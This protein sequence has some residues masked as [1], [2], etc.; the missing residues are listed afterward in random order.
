[1]IFLKQH[2]ELDTSSTTLAIFV[3]STLTL[4]CSTFTIIIYL[5]MKNLRTLVY[6]FFFHVA[7][8]EWINRL[9]YLAILISEIKTNVISFRIFSVIIY[10]SNTNIIILT[11]FTCFGM[12]QLILKQNTKL[13]DKF[14]KISIFLYIGSAVFTVIFDF[15]SR[16]DNN[17]K[18]KETNIYRNIICLYFITDEENKNLASVL[19][20]FILYLLILIFS[21][22][23]IILIQIFV[24][25][26]ASIPRNMD[27]EAETMKDK[28][29][30]SSLKLRTFK[31]KLL[32]YPFLNFS[33][34]VPLSVYLWIEYA[35]LAI[36]D[37]QANQDN[38]ENGIR[39]NINYL[40]ARYLFYNIYCFMN[41]IRGL[42]YFK[43]FNDNEKIK[44]YLFKNFLYFD[45]F[46]TIDQI[47]EEEVSNENSSKVIEADNISPIEKEIN[48]NFDENF[49][50]NNKNKNKLI[51]SETKRSKSE[52]IRA[53]SGLIEMNS[54]SK[55]PL[56]KAGL[57]NDKEDD[58]DDSD[59]SDDE[60]KRMSKVSE[61][62]DKSVKTKNN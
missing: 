2:I 31:L 34:I 52:I 32:A 3:F 42:L 37:K 5:R 57:I 35:Y 58:S 41:S 18:T 27:N 13:A 23:W 47:N 39:K 10:L 21:F 28:A 62:D 59:E 45:L 40:R 19:Y 38:K 1:M 53:D 11:A 48:K 16:D 56:G 50:I 33:Y 54:K 4:V 17:D 44:M 26:K 9:G 55:Q 29:I 51:N 7:I 61:S 60:S 12:Y 25:D 30:K 22:V 36:K 24:K 6:R 8:N 46:K 14:N 43:V 20:N 15:I 49:D